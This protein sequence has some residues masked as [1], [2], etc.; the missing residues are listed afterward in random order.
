[1]LYTLCTDKHISIGNFTNKRKCVML[2]YTYL[3]L[4]ILIINHILWIK[5]YPLLCLYVFNLLPITCVKSSELLLN[6]LILLIIQYYGI[7]FVLIDFGLLL[8]YLL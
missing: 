6:A 4:N 1:M 2:K 5:P 7:K 3:H 8:Y